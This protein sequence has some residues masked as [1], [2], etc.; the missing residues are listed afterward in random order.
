MN[1]IKITTTKLPLPPLPK[2]TN[3]GVQAKSSLKSHKVFFFLSFFLVF[4]SRHFYSC[5][6]QQ[7]NQRFNAAIVNVIE[8]IR[9]KMD[10]STYH[11]YKNTSSFFKRRGRTGRSGRYEPCL[12]TLVQGHNFKDEVRYIN[13]D[14]FKIWIWTLIVILL[15]MSIKDGKYFTCI[16]FLLSPKLYNNFGPIPGLQQSVPVLGLWQ[17]GLIIIM[18]MKITGW[19]ILGLW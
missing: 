17:Y 5:P 8:M 18:F 6:T 16:S 11:L 14:S 13:T 1:H 4:F 15:S 10:F 7:E 12:F 19:Y 3:C 9:F 2:K